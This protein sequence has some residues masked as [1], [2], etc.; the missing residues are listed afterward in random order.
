MNFSIHHVS[1]RPIIIEYEAPW[2]RDACL[3]RGRFSSYMAGNRGMTWGEKLNTALTH[4]RRMRVWHFSERD[5]YLTCLRCD[6][7]SIE[8]IS[9]LGSRPINDFGENHLFDEIISLIEITQNESI[10]IV[11]LMRWSPWLKS[12]NQSS[13]WRKSIKINQNHVFDQVRGFGGRVRRDERKARLAASDS[14][15]WGSRSGEHVPFFPSK[16]TWPMLHVGMWA[17]CCCLRKHDHETRSH[18]T[19][20]QRDLVP[21]YNVISYLV[22]V[23]GWRSGDVTWRRIEARPGQLLPL[24]LPQR[25][26]ASLHLILKGRSAPCPPYLALPPMSCLKPGTDPFP[27]RRRDFFLCQWTCDSKRRLY[28]FL[29]QEARVSNESRRRRFQSNSS[30]EETRNHPRRWL[31]ARDPDSKVIFPRSNPAK[32]DSPRFS[33]ERGMQID[34][35]DRHPWKHL[36]SIRVSRESDSNM[37]LSTFDREKQNFSRFSTDRGITIDF[38]D[39]H[40]EKQY[41]SSRINL[42]SLSNATPSIFDSEKHDFPRTR[43]QFGISINE[44]FPK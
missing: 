18:C 20:V 15:A 11:S 16:S 30:S 41:S 32:Q 44:S 42:D 6:L 26:A 14:A 25:K 12:L 37:M 10:K 35:S 34:F 40:D 9:S 24:N 43:I 27:V 17:V 31:V 3:P 1:N 5:R 36:S 19:M 8:E 23:P 22:R 38:I 13:L 7:V 21:G 28:A 29:K 33:T 39:L 4:C 2:P